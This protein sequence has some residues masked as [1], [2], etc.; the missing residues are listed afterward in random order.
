MCEESSQTKWR[1]SLWCLTLSIWAHVGMSWA[2]KGRNMCYLTC[3]CVAPLLCLDRVDQ[4]RQE[5]QC[6]SF[7]CAFVLLMSIGLLVQDDSNLASVDRYPSFRLVRNTLAV[8]RRCVGAIWLRLR[9]T[10]CPL[11]QAG[12]G[13]VARASDP[14]T[15][16]GP[17]ALTA[18]AWGQQ[19]RARP[20]SATRQHP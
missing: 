3:E 13:R 12:P 5:T 11:C 16:P 9:L 14:A 6:C 19:Q 4:G 2:T 18:G 1:V 20:G 8:F 10:C 15:P 7:I 17:A